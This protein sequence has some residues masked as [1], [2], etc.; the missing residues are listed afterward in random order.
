MMVSKS[1]LVCK[2]LTFRFHIRLEAKNWRCTRTQDSS[3]R[4]WL[5]LCCCFY[6]C[7]FSLLAFGCLLT[8]CVLSFV[9]VVVVVVVVHHLLESTCCRGTVRGRQ[10]T[11]RFFP[12]LNVPK[13]VNSLLELWSLSPYLIYP[14]AHESLQTPAKLVRQATKWSEVGT[15]MPNVTFWT[16]VWRD[17]LFFSRIGCSRKF[18]NGS[19]SKVG[20]ISTCEYLQE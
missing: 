2:R 6:C 15:F 8:S 1:N 7:C 3:W 14:S 17:L 9:V 19:V 12:G 16:S 4:C 13:V 5:R 11:F 20:C 18:V 10:T